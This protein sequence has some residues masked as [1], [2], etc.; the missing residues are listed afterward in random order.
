M[1]AV[2]ETLLSARNGVWFIGRDHWVV[3]TRSD[4]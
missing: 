3:F 1:A 4:W 2:L